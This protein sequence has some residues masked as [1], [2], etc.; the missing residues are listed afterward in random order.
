MT[1]E[2]LLEECR[3]IVE[4]VC[5]KYGYDREDT[6]GNDSL[7]TVLLKAVPAM[8]EDSSK[9]D[10][11]LFYQMLRHTPIAVTENLTEEGLAEL[12]KKYIGDINPHIIEEK[13]DNTREYGKGI[14]P[15]AFAAEPIIDE[16]MQIVGK[17]S[18]IYIPKVKGKA[19]EF[20]GTDIHV[21]DLEHELGHAWNAED[22][23]FT[24][25][26]QGILT[27]RVGAV[28]YKYSLNQREDGKIVMKFESVT[29]IYTEEA[30]NTIEEEKAVM[31]YLGISQ[32]ELKQAYKNGILEANAY[33]AQ[34]T[35]QVKHLLNETSEVDLKNWRKHGDEKGKE[36][37]ENLIEKTK[38]WEQLRNGEPINENF[39]NETK[40]NQ[41][42]SLTNPKA[43]EF[44]EKHHKVYFPDVSQMTPME[45]L[46][47]VL[48]Q[49]LNLNVLIQYIGPDNC[50][51]LYQQINAEYYILVNQAADIKA[52]EQ[53]AKCMG[54][55]KL[56]DVEEVTKETKEGVK[57][58]RIGE[59]VQEEKE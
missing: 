29:G 23:Q 37:V 34:I 38:A 57:S 27:N 39:N 28:K 25:D 41:I 1:K 51:L 49:S 15:G 53:I 40:R 18:F 12:R 3:G 33:Q 50:A 42:E 2:E 14:A 21:A 22:K 55:V 10:R 19:K 11:Q 35:N 7:R 8:L 30:M 9:E 24:I 44:F 56:S 31:R 48:E 20:F 5:E 32:E 4:E 58:L 36:E 52:K 26:D 45:K 43:Q 46:D 16:K 6:E 54:D 59:K 17:K 47:N 13:R